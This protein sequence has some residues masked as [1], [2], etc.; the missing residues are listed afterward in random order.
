M[1]VLHK[2]ALFILI[3]NAFLV[4]NSAYRLEKHNMKTQR[5]IGC[6][7]GPQYKNAP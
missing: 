7:N 6:V 5:E 3:L 4:T 2:E 1:L